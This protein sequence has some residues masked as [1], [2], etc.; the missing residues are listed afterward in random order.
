MEWISLIIGGAQ[1]A[2]GFAGYLASEPEHRSLTAFIPAAF[3][4]IIAISGAIV[5]F[6]PATR[7]HAMHAAATAALL[8]V[9]LVGG[10]A[11]FKFPDGGLKLVSFGLT[12]LL[13]VV[14]L[15]L[16]IRSFVEARRARERAAS[17]NENQANS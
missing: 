12:L 8:A 14:F 6:A 1:V 15:I 4:L 3:G 17:A 9:V 5:A 11:A 7:K 13:N 10:R 2:L 16:A